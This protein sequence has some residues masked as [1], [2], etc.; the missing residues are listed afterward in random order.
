M[1]LA[2]QL[3]EVDDWNAF[4]Q[5]PLVLNPAA[6]VPEAS[7]KALKALPDKVRILGDMVPLDYDLEGATPVVRLRLKEGQARRLRP[8]DLPELDRPLRFTVTRGQGPAV[9]ARSLEELQRALKNLPAKG[10][11]QRHRPPRRRR[12][13]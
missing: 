7:R 10:R 8:R 9:R 5:T 11:N 4:L 13:R 12:R 2:R 6:L 1:T 3:A